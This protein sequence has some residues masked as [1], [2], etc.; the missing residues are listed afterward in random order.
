V[1]LNDRID[2]VLCVIFLAVV[3]AMLVFSLQAM[4]KALRNPQVT[5]QESI[6]SSEPV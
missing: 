6:A 4:W 5:A 2:S 3:L 1:I